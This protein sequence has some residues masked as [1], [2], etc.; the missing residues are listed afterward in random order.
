MSFSRD[1]NSIGMW[2]IPPFDFKLALSSSNKVIVLYCIVLYCIVLYFDFKLVCIQFK[3]LG[4]LCVS[5]D[6]HTLCEVPKFYSQNV[7]SFKY[8]HYEKS[9]WFWYLRLFSI[10]IFWKISH[11]WIGSNWVIFY[12]KLA[13]TRPG[14]RLRSPIER[15]QWCRVITEKSRAFEKPCGGGCVS[16]I[17]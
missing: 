11:F 13:L 1:R 9:D 5:T 16:S 2:W 17:R 8:M 3:D 10:T 6:N 15:R 7:I 4:G 12:N 14:G